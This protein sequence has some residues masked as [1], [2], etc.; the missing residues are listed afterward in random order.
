MTNQSPKKPN[1]L[2]VVSTNSNFHAEILFLFLHTNLL[3]TSLIHQAFRHVVVGGKLTSGGGIPGG[4]ANG[5]GLFISSNETGSGCGKGCT[6][7]AGIDLL[8]GEEAG[9]EGGLVEA[10]VMAFAGHLFGE[11]IL[12][13]KALAVLRDRLAF[14]TEEKVGGVEDLFLLASYCQ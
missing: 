6:N 14:V 4:L 10:W 9:L 2:D 1:Y 7:A 11:Q 5:P 3:M 13:S 12:H 8:A